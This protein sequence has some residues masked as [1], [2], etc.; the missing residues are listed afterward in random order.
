VKKDCRGQITEIHVQREVS[1]Q[2]LKWLYPFQWLKSRPCDVRWIFLSNSSEGGPVG[3][4]KCG[5]RKEK[6]RECSDIIG[7]AKGSQIS[8]KYWRKV[9]KGKRADVYL[10]V[11]KRRRHIFFEWNKCLWWNTIL[12][13]LT[14]FVMLLIWDLSTAWTGVIS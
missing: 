4:F 2:T 14:V 8:E 11:R 7:S 10:E 9:G 5:S 6:Y 13:S 3:I 12:G 1:T